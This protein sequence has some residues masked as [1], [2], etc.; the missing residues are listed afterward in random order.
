[1]LGFETNKTPA[2]GGRHSRRALGTM[3]LISGLAACGGSEPPAEASS[4]TAAPARAAGQQVGVML[5]QESAVRLAQQASFGP[6]ETLIKDIQKQGPV[7]WVKAQMDL[8]VSRYTRGGDDAIHTNKSETGFC[9]LPKQLTN[10]NCWRDYYSTEPLSW[11]FY[12]NAVS[13]PDQLRQR[14]AFAL[15]QILVVSG[16]E[17]G[18][19]YGLR[20]YHNAL[21]DLSFS[22]YRDVLRRVTLSPVMGDYLDHVNN[23]PSAP[24][25]NYARELLQLFSLGPCKLQAN[26]ELQNGRCRATYDNEIVRNYAHALTGWTY[27]AGGKSYWGCWPEKA[28]CAYYGGNM[29]SV[30]AFH[31][32]QSRALLSGVVV[33]AGSTADQALELV[34]DSLMTHINIAPF[35]SKR[36]IQ[37]LVM[38]DPSPEYVNRVADAF[39]RGLYSADSSAGPVS[40]GAGRRGDL[41]ATVAAVLLDDDARILRSNPVRGGH[42]RSPVLLFTGA[43]RALNG[44]TDGAPLGWWWGETLR[45][46][47]FRPPSVFSYYPVDY[48]VAGT[49]RIGPEFGLHNTNAALNRLNYLTYLI[50][51]DGSAPDPNIPDATGTKVRLDAF[52]DDAGDSEKLVDRISGVVLGAPLAAAPREKVL[53]AVRYWRNDTAPSDWRL[54][55]VRTAAYLVLGSPDYQVQP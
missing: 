22:N 44:S 18:G 51:W 20:R 55:R 14:V 31:D 3:V 9:S 8:S 37:H 10:P 29:T 49:Q 42:L 6:S 26:G 54:R 12:R 15:H 1:M 7:A 2:A 46:H 48:P 23:N 38:S 11:D 27:P 50:D 25:E 35:V 24:N 17:I 30:A 33:P 53:A 36:L 43:I 13:Q 45:Q 41:A 40:F 19:T 52:L 16:V 39:R 34:L 21:L 4:S 32:K 5:S 47:I 28:N